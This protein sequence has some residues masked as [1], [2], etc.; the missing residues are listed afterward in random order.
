MIQGYIEIDEVGMDLHVVLDKVKDYGK[1]VKL[2]FKLID[3]EEIILDLISNTEKNERPFR[4]E[5]KD[6]LKLFKKLEIKFK[7]DKNWK[8][9][10][11]VDDIDKIVD[12]F[13]DMYWEILDFYYR[14]KDV[15]VSQYH[16]GCFL[17]EPK[18]KTKEELIKYWKIA[19]KVLDICTDL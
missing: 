4:Y 3:E 8:A 14:G 13:V 5:S 11:K 6:T 1:F 2:F 12:K 17:I 9:L 19:G 18:K 10:I 7:F 16:E 15:S